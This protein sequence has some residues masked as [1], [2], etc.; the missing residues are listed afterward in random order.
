MM[1][2]GPS[3]QET[4]AGV[5]GVL[6]WIWEFVCFGRSGALLEFAFYYSK[7]AGRSKRAEPLQQ[8]CAEE[9]LGDRNR[10]AL[11]AHMRAAQSRAQ[12]L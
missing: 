11:G 1:K 12:E 4:E 3:R 6:G 9:E 7:R 8:V 2:M 10:K 5:C